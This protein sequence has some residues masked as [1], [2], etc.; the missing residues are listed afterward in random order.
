MGVHCGV[1]H[2]CAVC[3]L[4][5]CWLAIFSAPSDLSCCARPARCRA[6]RSPQG[7]SSVL[8]VGVFHL[9]DVSRVN[10][11]WIEC[12]MSSSHVKCF[13]PCMSMSMSIS[14]SI[15][16]PVSIFHFPFSMSIFISISIYVPVS[17][18]IS[19]SIF[20]SRMYVG[21]FGPSTPFG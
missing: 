12:K 6:A 5:R 14:I 2:V 13:L 4:L 17:I 19:I 9:C 20:I 11:R 18:S 3:S 8:Q 7:M 16:V 1:L 15:S 21:V 10:G